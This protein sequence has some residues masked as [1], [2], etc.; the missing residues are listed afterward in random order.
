MLKTETRLHYHLILFFPSRFHFHL[1]LNTLISPLI[2]LCTSHAFTTHSNAASSR[3]SQ[4]IAVYKAFCISFKLQPHYSHLFSIIMLYFSC[5]CSNSKLI[6]TSS[7]HS[8][9][10]IHP[11][12]KNDETLKHP[13]RSKERWGLTNCQ[14]GN[15]GYT[16]FVLAQ[17]LRSRVLMIET[18]DRRWHKRLM[19]GCSLLNSW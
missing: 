15:S 4:I 3:L 13:R 18:I 2:L 14:M 6:L 16:V 11:L 8:Y 9:I 17:L 5:I 19:K 10:L 1:I 12:Q 7:F